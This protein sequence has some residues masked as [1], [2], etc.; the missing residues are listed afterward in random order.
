MRERYG[1]SQQ[2]IFIIQVQLQATVEKKRG[3]MGQFII[4][5]VSSTQGQVSPIL[6]Y[7]DLDPRGHCHSEKVF[8]MGATIHYLSFLIHMYL[9]SKPI[10]SFLPFIRLFIAGYCKDIWETEI[11]WY[12]K[13]LSKNIS[14][15]LKW[16]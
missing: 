11:Q 12:T 3:K 5:F 6:E 2:S 10:Q 16:V 4:F 1:Q 15:L 7:A 9:W 13:C 8:L 14:V